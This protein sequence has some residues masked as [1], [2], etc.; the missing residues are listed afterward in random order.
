M[1][2]RSFYFIRHGQSVANAEGYPAGRLDS[3]LTSQG[4]REA[5]AVREIAR[6]LNPPPQR[7]VTSTL[8]RARD[9]AAIINQ[10][11][12]LPVTVDEDL[13]EQDYGAY[14]GRPKEEM[15]A[16][17]GT[18]WYAAPPG[19]E[20]Y[21]DFQ[22]RIRDAVDRAVAAGPMPLIVGHGG[23]I[24]A[25]SYEEGA[26]PET[27]FKVGNCAVLRADYAAGDGRWIFAHI[28]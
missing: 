8:S 1:I 13:C 12:G 27:L 15:R 23:M 20:R 19:G 6:R 17:H 16:V 4:L 2:S 18:F 3:P 25:L 24:M 9:T 10:D 21:A 14:Q 5:Q 11:I 26:P 22:A 7:I 28:E